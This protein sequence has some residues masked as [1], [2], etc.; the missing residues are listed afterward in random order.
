MMMSYPA[1]P[2]SMYGSR[3]RS[4]RNER[5]RAGVRSGSSICFWRISPFCM[6]V[7]NRACCVISSNA[8]SMLMLEGK[9][10][11][12]KQNPSSWSETAIISSSDAFSRHASRK[13]YSYVAKT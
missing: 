9:V 12:R 8:S 11:F 2:R 13:R 6:P 10:C 7:L 1:M 3:W 5:D 4:S